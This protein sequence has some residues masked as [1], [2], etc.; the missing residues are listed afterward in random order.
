M[1]QLRLILPISLC[2]SCVLADTFAFS[3]TPLGSQQFQTL[4]ISYSTATRLRGRLPYEVGTFNIVKTYLNGQERDPVVVL[5]RGKDI[6]LPAEYFQQAGLRVGG[7]TELIGGRQYTTFHAQEFSTARF[8]ENDTRL[9][10]TCGPAC[11]EA[12]SM[13][14]GITDSHPLTPV[15]PGLFLNYDLFSEFGDRGEIHAGFTETGLFTPYGTGLNNLFCVSSPRQGCTRLESSWT[16]DN[17]ASKTRLRLGDAISA[18]A[19]WGAPVR[20]GGIR[21]GTDFS[22]NPDYLTFPTPSISG[23]AILPGTVSVLIN[24]TERFQSDVNPGLFTISDLPVVTGAGTVQAVVSDVLGRETL[25][26]TQ[27]YTAPQLLRKGL[28]DY[29]LE[30]GWLRERFG[31]HSNRYERPFLAASYIQGISNNFTMGMR[32]EISD[33]IASGG[34]SAATSHPH[35]GVLEGSFAVSESQGATGAQAQMSHEYSSRRLTIGSSVTHAS[36]EFTRIGETR[37]LPRT[38][39]R[40][41]L[42]WN[43]DSIGTTSLNWVN[44]DERWGSDYSAFGLAFN[45]HWRDA[46]IALSAL[47][48]TQP[49]NAFIASFRLSMPF[50]QGRTASAGLDYRR[51]KMGTSMRI[52][53][54]APLAGGIGYSAEIEADGI[55]RY[56]GGIQYRTSGGDI[57]A[58]LSDVGGQSAARVSLRGGI[59][60][61]SDEFVLTQTI[62]DS[63]AVVSLNGEAGVRIYHDRQLAGTTNKNGRLVVSDI[64]DYEQN[65]LS[66]EPTDLSLSAD[67]RST[68]LIVKPGL[69]TGHV[70]DFKIEHNVDVVFHINGPDGK[71]LSGGSLL[72]DE[73]TDVSYVVGSEGRVYIPDAP[74]HLYLVHTSKNAECALDISI[75]ILSTEHPIHDLG[76]FDCK[77]R[78]AAGPT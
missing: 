54:G 64:R 29:S 6:W 17:P 28:S 5:T 50:G 61:L 19:N 46:S 58:D 69:R 73:Q 9:D 55:D 62:T 8:S 53:K 56:Q 10:I 27:F 60:Y 78:R 67:F 66:F 45:S 33:N 7:R 42:G 37:P 39:A 44:Q 70:I 59:A 30:A 65:V 14:L 40:A 71:A 76:R 12:R 38:T 1:P 48:I 34:L 77:S 47:K 57:S 49:E 11:F 32:S 22:L 74:S 75:P 68:E 43:F 31:S 21:W 72:R 63:M 35:L 41:F 13:S 4:E 2:A 24:A 16:I 26:T 51:A 52:R 25:V 20:F 18:A 15:T 36:E 23:D 3:E